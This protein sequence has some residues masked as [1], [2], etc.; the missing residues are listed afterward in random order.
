MEDGGPIVR[1]AEV[2]VAN[3]H[4]P[5][6]GGMGMLRAPSRSVRWAGPHI[7]CQFGAGL[8]LELLPGLHQLHQQSGDAV[9]DDPKGEQGSD[10]EFVAGDQP[11]PHHHRGD[12]GEVTDAFGEGSCGFTA[13]LEFEVFADEAA[14]AVLEGPAGF[15][16]AFWDL[17][18][19]SVIASVR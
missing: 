4:G 13:H 6:R 14:V 18:V 1:V 2:D 19:D 10:R 9:A 15:S 11:D 12:A 3:G 5:C 7:S 8:D 17:I 16:S